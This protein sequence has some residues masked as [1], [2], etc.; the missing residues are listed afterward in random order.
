MAGWTVLETTID[1]RSQ[2]EVGLGKP[3]RVR[4]GAK[5][6]PRHWQGQVEETLATGLRGGKGGKAQ[7]EDT[8][9]C[10]PLPVLLTPSLSHH[11]PL[12]QAMLTTGTEV[13]QGGERTVVGELGP[14][15]PQLVEEA[16]STGL[17]RGEPGGRRVLQQARAESDGLG[18]CPG[19]EH[20]WVHSEGETADTRAVSCALLWQPASHT[21]TTPGRRH[22]LRRALAQGP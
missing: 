2:A 19:F 21:A 15:T 17:Q 13:E 14:K 9:L 12:A 10:P 7:C 22:T 8:G 6:G 11:P 3:V 20:L 5:Q 1:M 16:V 4:M 18:R